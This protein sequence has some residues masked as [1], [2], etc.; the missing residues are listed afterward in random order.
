MKL[1]GNKFPKSLIKA[2]QGS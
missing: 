1:E 2:N